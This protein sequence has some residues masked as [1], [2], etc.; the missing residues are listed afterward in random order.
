MDA[1]D[2]FVAGVASALGLLLISA[3]IANSEW[4][5]ALRKPR[6]ISESLGRPAARWIT[7]GV[8]LA[9]LSLAGYLLWTQS[10]G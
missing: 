6:R 8:G 9:V 5:F 7:V 10:Q 1:Q 3:S 4:F 2:W